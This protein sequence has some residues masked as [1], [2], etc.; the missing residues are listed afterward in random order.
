MQRTLADLD[1]GSEG[2]DELIIT[3]PSCGHVFTVETLDGHCELA[4]YYQRDGSD[5]KWLGLEAPPPGFRQ[6]P[7]CPTCRSAITAP[8]Y[9]RVFKRADLDILE[10]NVAF[11]MSKSLK[12]VQAKMDTVSKP[13]MKRTVEELAAD[14]KA[15]PLKIST[16]ELKGLQRDQGVLLKS[17]RSIPLILRHIDPL[18]NGLHGLPADEAKALKKVILVLFAAY[19]DAALTSQIRSAHSHAWEASFA[20]L[21]Q[22]EMDDIVANP[23]NAPRNPQEYAMRIARMKVGQPPPRADKR[24]LVEAFWTTI[25]I[26]LSVASFTGTWVEAVTS[27]PKYPPGNRRVWASYVVFILRSCAA[28]AEIALQI[29]RE[30]ESF[31]QE[32]STVLLLM[33]IE[34]EQFRFNVQMSKQT[35]AKMTDAG[36]AKLADTAKEKRASA[37]QRIA[38]VRA[39]GEGRQ[40]AK[41]WL[42]SDFVE[43]TL[44]ILDDWKALERSLRN[45]TFYEPVS[46]E[47]LT[48]IVKG[49]NFSHTGHFYKCPNGHV[50]VITE[51]GGAM[52]TSFCMDC[53]EPI[54]GTGHNLLSTNSQATELEDI[55]R[56]QGSQR[57][58]WNWGV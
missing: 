53:G 44:A 9:G 24:F 19:K 20:Y 2:L 55:A 48:Q 5:G 43:P 7:T 6:P 15:A 28:D 33:R 47:E 4:Q 34:L 41:N 27:R 3:I 51:C 18:N 14:I 22:K 17:A 12:A 25:N 29:T 8:R 54:G 37:E 1:H 56:A 21:Y 30:S 45:D 16:K 26:R 40:G 35:T 13:T 58:P 31:R 42:H 32:A 38:A 50:F 39:R 46:L 49:L 52:Q 11:H 36:R 57:S 10:N 23:V